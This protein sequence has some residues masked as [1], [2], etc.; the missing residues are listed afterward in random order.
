MAALSLLSYRVPVQDTSQIGE[1]RRLALKAAA[2]LQFSSTQNGKVGIVASELATNLAKHSQG[3]EFIVQEIKCGDH[4]GLELMTIDTGPGFGDVAKV[5]RDGFSTAG[6]HGT[7]LGAVKR[8]SHVLDIYSQKENGSVFA[9]EVWA[10]ETQCTRRGIEYGVVS[11]PHHGERS[12]GDCWLFDELGNGRYAALI[13]DGLGH[14]Q[15]ASEAAQTAL[16]AY[17]KVRDKQ[18]ENVM[19]YCHGALR[20]TRGAAM[21]MALIDAGRGLVEYAGIGNIVAGIVSESGTRR[22]VS[23]DGTVGHSVARVQTF[24]YPWPKDA[25]LIMHS[26]GLTANWNLDRYPG[27]LSRTPSVIAGVLYRDCRR[28]NDDATVLVAKQT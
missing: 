17:R 21:A 20:S 8:L 12:N 13:V 18:P 19:Q 3:G 4:I 26:D 5:M 14:G 24:T 1:A 22:M 16:E 28:K 25:V 11:V 23:H 6:S 9:A 15:F 27:L 10:N 2:N 7:G